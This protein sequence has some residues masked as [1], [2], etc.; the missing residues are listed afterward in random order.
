MAE[1]NLQLTQ[2]IATKAVGTPVQNWA[3]DMR[4]RLLARQENFKKMLPRGVGSDRFVSVLVT[5]L[6]QNAGTLA[7]CTP[8]SLMHCCARLAQDGLDP[9]V[10]NEASLVPFKGKASVIR[11]YKGYM[12]MARRS[13]EIAE[14]DACEFHELDD[15]AFE[16]GSNSYLRHSWKVGQDRGAL[17]GFYAYA[18]LRSGGCQFEVL[19]IPDTLDH[20]RRFTR[21]SEKGPFAG[22]HQKGI[23]HENFVPYGLKTALIRLCTRKLDMLPEVANALAEESG[24]PTTQIELDVEPVVEVMEA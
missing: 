4:A 22:L 17:K 19:D 8:E 16:K 21:A 11:G 9:S 12:K 3:A 1:S 13:D 14:I 2:K 23:D 10:P 7:S 15:F 6:I 18:K 24:E 20:A 5:H